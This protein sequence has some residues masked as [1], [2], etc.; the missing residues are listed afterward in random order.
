MFRFFENLVD[1]YVPYQE[2]D[3]PP[4]R[5]LPFLMDYARPFHR[6]FA[7]TAVLTTAVAA[8]EVGLIWYVGRIVDLLN[9]GTPVEVMRTHGTEFLIAALAVLLVRPIIS[10]ADVALLHNTILPNFGTLIRWRSHRHVL[11]QP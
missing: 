1:P 6:V 9:A 3:T 8:M 5:L 2:T 11:R 4:R 10:G 7:V